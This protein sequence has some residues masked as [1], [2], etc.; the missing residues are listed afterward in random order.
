VC[1]D[2]PR[3]AV[4]TDA[5]SPDFYFPVW[6]QYYSS[7]VGSSNLYVVTYGGMKKLFDKYELGGAW[8][9]KAYSNDSRI[10]IISTL[11]DLLLQ[12]YDYVIR[13]DT[14]E[15]IV[16]DPRTFGSLRSYMDALNRP[17][18]TAMSYDVVQGDREKALDL[19]QKILLTQRMFAYPY[20]AL[21][22]TCVTS[23]SLNWAPG[24]HFCSVYPEFNQLYLFHLKRADLD[25]QLQV[26]E[27]TAARAPGE[28]NR[29]YYLTNQQTLSTY[30][31]TVLQFRSGSGWEWFQ[32][33]EYQA[34][35]LQGIKYTKNYGG[36]YHGA[37]FRPEKVLVEIP[38]EFKGSF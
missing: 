23:L 36:V 12:Q 35:F 3:A 16:P 18:V 31:K 4:V 1:A 25:I 10:K 30:N 20:D 28:R 37:A 2:R 9:V 6:H 15:L 21:N 19:E 7:Q 22:K 32:R 13:V 5:I 14:D 33:D 17:Y 8:E 24:F 27:A 29:D 38:E 26:G 11:V 34:K